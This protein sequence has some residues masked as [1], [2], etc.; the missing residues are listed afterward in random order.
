MNYVHEDDIEG[1]H[2]EAP[3]KRVIKHLSS[4]WTLGSKNLWVG[5]STVAP[6]NKTNAHSHDINEEVFYCISGNGIFIAD[7]ET[8]EYSSGAV[9]Y[10]P[11]GVVHQVVNTGDE[12]L[13]SICC[14]SPP[15]EQQQFRDDH[16]ME[17]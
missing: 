3:F 15:F 7:D 8:H 12:P 16:A 10:V 14:V 11:P 17:S 9:I 13:K 2:I 1:D 4:P 6:G 5:T